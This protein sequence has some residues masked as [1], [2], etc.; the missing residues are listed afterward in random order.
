MKSSPP[1]KIQA[2]EAINHESTKDESTKDENTTLVVKTCG[3]LISYFRFSPFRDSYW[4]P[5][6][7]RV[8]DKKTSR[9][10]AARYSE[11]KASQLAV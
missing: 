3:P 5:A 8:I 6:L 11:N 7:K 4:I 10:R 2:K 9:R 1:K